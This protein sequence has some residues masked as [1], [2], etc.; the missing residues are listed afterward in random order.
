[1]VDAIGWVGTVAVLVAYALVTRRGVSLAYQALNLV[2]AGA[3]IVDAVAHHAAPVVA[4]NA[5]WALIAIVGLAAL[6]R[7]QRMEA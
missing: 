4:L 2:G 7:R 1:M 5:A 3:L 6:G